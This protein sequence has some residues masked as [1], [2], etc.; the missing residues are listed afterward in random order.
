VRSGTAGASLRPGAEVQDM[1]SEGGEGPGGDGEGSTDG[2]AAEVDFA[3]HGCLKC[4]A[5]NL[6]VSQDRMNA[7]ALQLCCVPPDSLLNCG[8]SLPLNEFIN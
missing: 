8:L 5:T 7:T 3:S 1:D 6:K 4:A 2:K